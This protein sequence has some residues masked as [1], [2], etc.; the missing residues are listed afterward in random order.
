MVAKL[1][2]RWNVMSALRSGMAESRLGIAGISRSKPES[3]GIQD[4]NRAGR[5]TRIRHSLQ[6]RSSG[7]SKHSDGSTHA[8]RCYDLNYSARCQSKSL[9]MGHLLLQS[10]RLVTICS[11]AVRI[12]LDPELRE[13][14]DVAA[15]CCHGVRTD[16]Q[17]SQSWDEATFVNLL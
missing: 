14:L 11:E 5:G 10:R 8:N 4:A 12:R 7:V 3:P 16:R 2:R 17:P 15:Q 9:A 13:S 6:F 1:S